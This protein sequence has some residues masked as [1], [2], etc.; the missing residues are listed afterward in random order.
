[1]NTYQTASHVIACIATIGL[2][3]CGKGTTADD[4]RE[5]HVMVSG[6]LTAAYLEVAA[7]FERTS[8]NKLV[9]SFGASMGRAPDSIPARLDRGEP[10]DVLIMVGDALDDLIERGKAVRGSRVD[11]ANS[12]IGMVVRAGAPKPDISSVASVKR[13]LLQA[14]SIAYSA[15][16]SGRYISTELFPRLGIT[17]QVKDKS[18]QILSERVGSVVA[19]GDSEVGFQQ[20]SELLPIPGVDF[21]G[22]LPPE[23]QKITVFSAGITTNARDEHAARALIEFLVH[24][25]APAIANSGMEP[26]NQTK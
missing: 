19:R 22:P 20:I 8:G 23:L 18:K 6:G 26:I 25:A 24:A 11:L 10:A 4:S 12:R 1:M 2:F 15:S 3:G 21:V 5:L 13:T 7:Q 9:T 16:A 17:E 14:T